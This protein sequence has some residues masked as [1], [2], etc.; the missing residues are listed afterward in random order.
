MVVT[1]AVVSFRALS[2]HPA[3]L[4]RPR[5]FSLTHCRG[6]ASKFPNP[7]DK[8]NYNIFSFDST[9][10]TKYRDYQLVDANSLESA[11][12]PPRKVKMLARDFIEDSLYNPNY[13]YFTKQ[14]TIFDTQDSTIKFETLRD[15]VE[16]QE[17]VGKRYAA[18]GADNQAGPGKQLWHTPTELFKVFLL[19]ASLSSTPHVISSQPWYGRAI[20]Q[21][22]VAEYLLKY[23][24]YEDFI[25]YE[26]GAGNGTLA[27]DILNYLQE[28]YPDVYERTRYNIIEISGS[29]VQLQKRKLKAHPCVKITHK[30]IFHWRTKEPAPCFFVAME[31][32]VSMFRNEMQSTHP[33][34]G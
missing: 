13:G 1:L 6:G 34:P 25:V 9:P 24:P 22:L 30:S 26:I 19:L 31:V 33:T 8:W 28:E 20:A 4:V 11:K 5:L 12:E 27:M 15:S 14:A 3:Q 21:C 7:R 2:R 18:Y 32:I 10:D 17:E 29:L 23:F 16:F